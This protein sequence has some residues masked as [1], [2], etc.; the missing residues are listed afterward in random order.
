MDGAPERC[1]TNV[2]RIELR[3]T[4]GSWCFLTC[5]RKYR[6][7]CAHA[8]RD[9]EFNV[10]RASRQP[11]RAASKVQP[12]LTLTQTLLVVL[13]KPFAVWTSSRVPRRFGSRTTPSLSRDT[14]LWIRAHDDMEEARWS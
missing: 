12:L 10:D 6:V 14:P 1:N 13:S 9:V 4:F 5:L 2:V 3:R 11:P 7:D 8:P